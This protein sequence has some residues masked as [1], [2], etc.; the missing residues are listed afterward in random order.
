[1]LY[2]LEHEMVLEFIRELAFPL[3]LSLENLIAVE[4]SLSYVLSHEDHKENIYL[5]LKRWP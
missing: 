1:M 4:S 2:T 3:Y 5:D